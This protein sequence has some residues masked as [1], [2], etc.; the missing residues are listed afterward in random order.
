MFRLHLICWKIPPNLQTS[1]YPIICILCSL[2][3]SEKCFYC[4]QL[5]HEIGDHT[6][7]KQCKRSCKY[8]NG[9]KRNKLGVHH[10]LFYFTFYFCSSFWGKWGMSI[11]SMNMVAIFYLKYS[12]NNYLV[13]I[14]SK[15]SHANMNA[16]YFMYINVSIKRP[17][18]R[19]SFHKAY[20]SQRG[21]LWNSFAYTVKLS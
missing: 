11:I 9:R 5:W 8:L 12:F 16:S 17:W 4:V 20:Y 19:P 2:F 18:K 6:G 13:N 3:C 7:L 21:G 1:G 10:F 15:Y 14:Y